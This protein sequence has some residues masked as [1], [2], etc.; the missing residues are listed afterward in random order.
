MDL[1][2]ARQ[3]LGNFGEFVGAVAVLVALIYLARQ[4]SQTA[5]SNESNAIAQAASD[6]QANMRLITDNPVLAVELGGRIHHRYRAA[7]YG[8]PAPGTS[9]RQNSI[10]PR[11]SLAAPGPEPAAVQINS[12]LRSS[13]PSMQA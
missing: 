1:M 2:S 7:S 9:T 11:G 3:Q 4:L 6:H 13:P 5:K 10:R 8:S 12:V